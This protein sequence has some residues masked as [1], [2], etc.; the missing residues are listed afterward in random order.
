MN[1][2]S[3]RAN[4]STAYSH[5]VNAGGGLV[6]A[7][8]SDNADAAVQW[9]ATRTWRVKL[10]GDY[11]TEHAVA[12][13]LLIPTLQGHSIGGSFMVEHPISEQLDLNLEYDR[14]HQ[15]FVGVPVILNNPNSNRGMITLTWQ[16]D[17]PLGR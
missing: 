15:S 3:V 5:Q 9:R 1:W 11:A 10:S 8:R 6:G 16:L 2:Q 14:L 13:K 12:R 17:R 7:Y 4:I